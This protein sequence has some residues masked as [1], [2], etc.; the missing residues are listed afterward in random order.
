MIIRRLSRVESGTKIKGVRRNSEWF[1]A[2][3]YDSHHQYYRT[4]WPVTV[5]DKLYG[6]THQG[7]SPTP[8]SLCGRLESWAPVL[9][10]LLYPSSLPWLWISFHSR[11]GVYF[12]TLWLWVQ[13]FDLLQPIRWYKTKSVK[14][15]SLAEEASH[16]SACPFVLLP[17]PWED[18]CPSQPAGSKRMRDME[19]SFQISQTGWGNPQ[20]TRD[21]REIIDYHHF[22]SWHMG[23]L[24]SNSFLTHPPTVIFCGEVDKDLLPHWGPWVPDQHAQ[25]PL[26]SHLGALIGRMVSKRI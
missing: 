5:V 18:F 12:L 21:A 26:S 24:P 4:D 7:Y 11:S 19:Q 13:P 15:L 20:L 14:V 1:I 10:P 9:H 17:M 22:M 23:L 16:D 2:S 25:D 6:F 3:G 8:R